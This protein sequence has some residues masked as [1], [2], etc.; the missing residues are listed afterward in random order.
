MTGDVVA[1]DVVALATANS[2][3]RPD[4]NCDRSNRDTVV[5]SRERGGPLRRSIGRQP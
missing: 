3:R 2:V 5:G 4:G 1:E